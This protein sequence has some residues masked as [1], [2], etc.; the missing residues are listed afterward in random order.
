M[1]RT[2]K[3][4]ADTLGAETLGDTSLL[5]DRL[6]EPLEARLGDLALAIAP[7]FAEQLKAS[8]ARAAV[9]WAGAD[10][11]A[12][13]LNGAIIAP[14]SRLAMVGL[15]QAMDD[16]PA[17]FGEPAIHPSAVID[18][19]AVIGTGA[20]IGPFVSIGARSRVGANAR[21]AAHVSIGAESIIGVCTTLHTGVRIGARILIGDSFIAQTGAVI[22]SD[23]F[24]FTTSG[25]SN[26]ERAIR[27]RPGAAL[28][29]MD[30]TWHR[31]HS[32][33]G[34]AIGDNVEIGANSTIDSGTVRATQIGN[35]V[36]IDNLVHVAHNVILGED[37]LLCAQVGIAG[38]S[39]LGARVI[40]G[41][42]S[43]VA[44]NLTVGRDVVIGGGAGVLANIPDGIFVLGYPAQP[45]HEYRSGLKAMRRLT[46]L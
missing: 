14:Y 4:L 46:K 45:S 28:E 43:G 16:D 9:V 11:Q 22:G 32:L 36:K 33:G 13:G 30:G 39:V 1:S 20:R 17:F 24:S 10:L 37:C 34:V 3:E 7:K 23:G 42:Q 15:T 27:A 6:A 18:E 21:I 38:S 44:D 19:T 12:L 25:P 29:P 31:I 2:L 8:A 5:V 40:M 26:V 41:G 35:G